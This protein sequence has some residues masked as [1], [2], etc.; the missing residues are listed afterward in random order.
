MRPW[1]D[2][3]R[4]AVDIAFW[5]MAAGVALLVAYAAGR[6]LVADQFV[7]P[8]N[9]MMPTLQPGDRVIVDKTAMGARIYRNLDFKPEGQRLEAFRLKGRRRLHA[10]DVAVFNFPIIDDTI[11]FRINYVYCKRIAAA[12]GD[13]LWA[14]GGYY[15]NS[16]CPGLI[17]SETAQKRLADLKEKPVG[18]EGWEMGDSSWGWTIRDFGPYYA[19]RRGDLIALTPKEGR[20]YRRILEHET[21]RAIEV[22]DSLG[23]VLADGEPYPM[24]E[25]QDSYYFMAGDYVTDSYDSRYWGLVPEEHIVGAV[26][27]IT[28]SKNRSDGS[29]RRDRI[30]KSL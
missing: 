7:I 30:L 27:L 13:S 8:T 11:S 4:K 5:V 3:F 25:F 28:Y 1:P 2:I 24:H 14:V 29:L 19:P 15:R 9:S 10:G 17:G 6:I 18:F 20:L 21:H 12:P 26:T 16:N 23:I 22:D